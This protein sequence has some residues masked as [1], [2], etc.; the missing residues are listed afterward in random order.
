MRYTRFPVDRLASLILR[1]V[2]TLNSELGTEW[3]T[4]SGQRRV[5][6]ERHY[7]LMYAE[8]HVPHRKWKAVKWALPT[9]P[10]SPPSP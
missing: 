1:T 4:S 8:A 10:S 6:W 9:M 2:P 3:R 5:R 7:T